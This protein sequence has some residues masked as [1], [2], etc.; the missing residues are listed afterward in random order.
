[1]AWGVWFYVF[2]VF[3]WLLFY[4]IKGNENHKKI[5]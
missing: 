5:F 4:E 2:C 3:I 1:M